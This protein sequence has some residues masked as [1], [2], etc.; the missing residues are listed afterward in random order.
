MIISN[1]DYDLSK[2]RGD[3]FWR[4]WDI[5]KFT[6]SFQACFSPKGV[7]RNGKYG[8]EEVTSVNAEGKWIL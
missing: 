6:P 3:Y 1:P 7:F 2:L 8:Y 5:V 4:S